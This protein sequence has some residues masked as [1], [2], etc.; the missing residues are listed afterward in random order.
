MEEKEVIKKIGKGEPTEWVNS[1]L[2]VY[3]PNGSLKICM[4]PTN[5]NKCIKRYHYKLPTR[6]DIAG[7]SKRPKW[8]SKLEASKGFYQMKLN[9]EASKLCTF[10]MADIGT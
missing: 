1:M 8:F 6:D 9:E 10:N 2:V 7:K 3:K 5:L 4:H